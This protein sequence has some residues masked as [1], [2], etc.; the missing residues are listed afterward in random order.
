MWWFKRWFWGKETRDYRNASGVF[1]LGGE[2]ATQ[3]LAPEP[4]L[5]AFRSPLITENQYTFDS[6]ITFLDF[7]EGFKLGFVEINFDTDTQVLID[8]VRKHPQGQMWQVV[9]LDCLRPNIGFVLDEL[10]AQ[11]QGV[12]VNPNQ[13][14][15]VVVQGLENSIGMTGDYPPLLV[16]LNYV[17]NAFPQKIPHPVLFV[18]PDYALTRLARFAPDFWDWRAG[19]FQFKTPSSSL[20]AAF[21][22]VFNFSKRLD[23]ARTV[24]E[25]WQRASLLQRLA[26]GYRPLMQQ[27]VAGNVQ[28]YVRI[29][30]ELGWAY[31]HLGETAKAKEQYKTAIVVAQDQVGMEKQKS[32]LFYR[33]ARLKS[34]QGKF[35]EAMEL[36]HQSLGIAEKIGDA[37]RKASNLHELAYIKKMK[38]DTEGAIELYH[39]SL[40]IFGK[41]GD[42]RR[43]ADTLHGLAN[44]KRDQGKIEESTF[45]Y[46]ESLDIDNTIGNLQG[47]AANLNRLADIKVELGEI[48]GAI[49]L[50]RQSLDIYKKIGNVPEKAFTLHAFA[51]IKVKQGEIEEAIEPYKQSLRIFKK[52]GNVKWESATLHTLADVKVRQGEIQEAIELYQQSLQI[53]EKIGNAQR[54]AITLRQLGKVRGKQGELETANQLLQEALSLAEQSGNVVTKALTLHEIGKLHLA[55]GNPETAQQRF[56]QALTLYQASGNLIDRAPTLEQ[57]AHLAHQHQDHPTALAHQREAIEIYRK[58]GSPQLKA[59]QATLH[60]WQ[61]SDLE[62]PEANYGEEIL[63]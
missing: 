60:Q 51:N 33:F 29:L 42:I 23:G 50:Y 38:G 54:K 30:T 28:N 26:M 7:A 13:K 11:L 43:K 8:T 48:E 35:E 63:Q 10:V 62:Q 36:Y 18:L 22:Q 61:Q 14:L 6:L 31:D 45:L 20:D 47:K 57:L 9:V 1:T 2:T 3:T 27:N 55:Q 52:I 21:A 25:W 58:I 32:E 46:Q 19:V 4:S 16:D 59:A 37:W 39:Q 49:E 17:R 5:V 40:D 44:I 24:V 15:I 53:E 34:N 41:I 12:T 56:Q